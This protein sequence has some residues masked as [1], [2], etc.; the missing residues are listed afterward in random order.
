MTLN[1]RIHSYII[2]YN[3]ELERGGANILGSDIA[4]KEA[5]AIRKISNDDVGDY[6]FLGNILFVML[7]SFCD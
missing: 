6:E 4:L 5:I 1:F 2:T 7:C 3:N